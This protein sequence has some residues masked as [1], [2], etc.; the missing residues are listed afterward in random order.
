MERTLIERIWNSRYGYYVS[1]YK[2]ENEGSKFATWVSNEDTPEDTYQGHYFDN[3]V[4][5]A[6]DYNDRYKAGGL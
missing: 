2:L 1:I 4:S 3:I 5:A 6:K